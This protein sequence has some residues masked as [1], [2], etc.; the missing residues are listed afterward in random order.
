MSCIAPGITCSR[1]RLSPRR[2]ATLKASPYTRSQPAT[3]KGSPNI[4]SRGRCSGRICRCSHSLERVLHVPLPLVHL[5]EVDVALRIGSH[6][7]DVENLLSAVSGP[8]A[9][10][11]H[12]LE[13][14]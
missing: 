1:A 2:T 14:S 3:L 6:A 5:A 4:R 12:N 11:I 10:G 9:H 13:R 8:P 7:V